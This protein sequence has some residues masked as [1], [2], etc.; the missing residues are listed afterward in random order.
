[1]YFKCNKSI[2][3]VYVIW[4]FDLGYLDGNIYI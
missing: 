3:I 1:M 2:Y 4:L